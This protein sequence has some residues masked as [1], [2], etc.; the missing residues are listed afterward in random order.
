MARGESSQPR[1]MPEFGDTSAQGADRLGGGWMRGLRRLRLG[2]GGWLGIGLVLLFVLL[3]A[4]APMLAPNDPTLPHP[5]QSLAE[6]SRAFPLGTDNL[7]RCLLSR[8]IYGSRPR[9]ASPPW[10]RWRS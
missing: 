4:A 8:L 3:A 2:W 10:R 7:G 6:P 1:A 9:W 5:G